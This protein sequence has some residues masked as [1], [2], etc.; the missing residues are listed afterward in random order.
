MSRKF[1]FKFESF[2]TLVNSINIIK[3]LLRDAKLCV[4]QNGIFSVLFNIGRG[5]RQGDP[6]FSYLYLICAEIMGIL[7][8]N[9]TLIKGIT[10]V[11]KEFKLFQYA[12]DTVLLLDGSKNSLY[13]QLSPSLINFQISLDLNHTMRKT[14]CIKIGSQRYDSVLRDEFVSLNW[15]QEPF[16]VLGII[17]CVSLENSSMFEFNF[18]PKIKEMKALI[19]SWL[20]KSDGFKIALCAKFL[21]QIHFLLLKIGITNSKICT[22]CNV[23]P[24]TLNHLFWGC[25]YTSEIWEEI[26]EW[27]KEL[28]GIEMNEMDIIIENNINAVTLPIYQSV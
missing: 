16:T 18:T 19:C 4:I 8:R 23:Y 6:I 5:C 17:Y 13:N 7:I 1:F 3:V 15:S 9:N 20:Y 10:T 14:Q 24:E 26:Y 21:F 28:S 22:F 11:G 12:D 25:E 2:L 27:I